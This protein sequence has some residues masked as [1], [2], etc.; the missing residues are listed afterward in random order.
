MQKYQKQLIY[1][2]LLISIIFNSFE[3]NKILKIELEK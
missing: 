3:F 1:N 2:I